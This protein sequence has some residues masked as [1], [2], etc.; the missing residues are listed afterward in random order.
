M[1]KK[2]HLITLLFLFI[3]C[4]L[5]AQTIDSLRQKIQEIVSTR[6]AIVGIAITGKQEKDTLYINKG[7]HFPMQSV[8]K[9][10]IALVVLSEIDKGKFSLNQKI[11]ISKEDLLSDT[12]S[13]I[14]DEYPN[15]ATLALSQI[16]EYTVSKSDNNGCD[17]LLRLIGGTKK[18]DE[19]FHTIGFTD[20]SIK[21]TEGEMHKEWNVQFQ[22]WITPKAANE[23]L[24]LFYFNKKK[25]LSK[26][27]YHF[28]WKVMRETETGKDRLKGQLPSN[29]IVAHKTGTSGA[30]DEGLTAAVND[31]GIIFLPN[32]DPVFISVFVTNSKE[33]ADANEKIIADIAKVTWG[34]FNVK[35]K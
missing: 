16:I 8:Y 19:Y 24:E 13:P 2:I 26:E 14:R 28:I 11:Q 3:T 34:Y 32:G 27:S 22:N 12:W 31:I 18:V 7:R 10:P 29:T 20:I 15:G 30:N 25:L 17:I 6:N 21:A 9:F 33:N 1:T 5:S 23:L 35:V 4:Q